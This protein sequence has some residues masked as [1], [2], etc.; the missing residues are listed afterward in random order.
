M[1]KDI[2]NLEKV[3][4]QKTNT[5]GLSTQVVDLIARFNLSA[6]ELDKLNYAKDSGGVVP[7]NVSPKYNWWYY[8]NGGKYK[9]QTLVQTFEK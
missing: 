3:V 2:H 7:W 6:L 9:F 5:D 4:T 1:A 8:Y